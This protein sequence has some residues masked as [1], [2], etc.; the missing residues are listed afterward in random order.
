MASP[1]RKTFFI[2]LLVA[3]IAAAVFF[4]TNTVRPEV[5]EIRT[6]ALIDHASHD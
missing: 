3:F 1:I 5:S 6:P 2:V 4:S